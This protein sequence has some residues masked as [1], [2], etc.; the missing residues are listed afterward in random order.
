ML[1]FPWWNELEGL[2]GTQETYA[3]KFCEP[4]VQ[5]IV[6]LNRE[7]FEPNAE[8]VAEALETL[9]NNNLCSLHSYDSLNDQQNEDM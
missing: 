8:A 4:E 5:T 9:R 3:S 6:D 7:K 2:T 1:Y